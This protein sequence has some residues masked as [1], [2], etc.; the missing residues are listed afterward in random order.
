MNIRERAIED[1]HKTAGLFEQLY[2]DMKRDYC[3]SSFSYGRKKMDE[4]FDELLAKIPAGGKILDAG[5]GT[6]EQV[7]HFRDKGFEVYGVEPADDMRVK[8]Q[9]R[10][11]GATIV[12]GLV[13]ELPFGDGEFDA[14]I[15]IEVL[16]YLDHADNIQA[17]RE[18]LRV[19]KPGGLI[20]VSLV[21]RWALD[22]FYLFDHFFHLLSWL[23]RKE[24][25]IH[26]EYVTPWQVRRELAAITD[27]H[28][29]FYGRMIGPLRIIYKVCRP[30]GA[31]CAKRLE[32]VDDW[33][34]RQQWSVPFA[35][36]LMLVIT[37]K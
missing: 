7:K 9:Q 20:I 8:A 30:L 5:C 13:T 23:T 31:W 21:N 15:C 16:R 22:G 33:I 10:N 35:G 26:C 37:K 34:S 32:K 14:V 27:S 4:L 36:H 2:A 29:E 1:H 6:G 28:V 25:P 19:T 17:Y 24:P 3:Y 18:M 12:K 11:P